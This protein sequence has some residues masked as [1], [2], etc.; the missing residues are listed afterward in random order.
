MIE[1]ACAGISATP[2]TLTSSSST[3]AA[4]TN[5][6]T[7]TVKKRLE[8]VGI[9]P[10]EKV[11]EQMISVDDAV[12]P[13]TPGTSTSSSQTPTGGTTTPDPRQRRFRD[14]FSYTSDKNDRWLSVDELRT[15]NDG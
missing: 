6:T 8:V 4:N 14:G 3:A 2:A 13:P 10:G 12:E 5:A 9:R 15:L 11:H 1:I 7:L